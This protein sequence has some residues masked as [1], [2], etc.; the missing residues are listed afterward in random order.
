MSLPPPYICNYASKCHC[1]GFQYNSALPECAG[2]YY[3]SAV[4]ILFAKCQSIELLTISWSI[5]ISSKTS[6]ASCS[7]GRD[8]CTAVVAGKGLFHRLTSFQDVLNR[9]PVALRRIFVDI[10]YLERTLN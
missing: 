10:L 2:L 6:A 5:C 1:T 3:T 9:Q 8:S 4:H 7:S